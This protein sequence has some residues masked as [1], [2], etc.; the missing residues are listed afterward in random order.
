MD[1]R[2]TVLKLYVQE[3]GEQGDITDFESRKRFQKTVYLG[4][5]SGVDIG[6]RYG[7]YIKGPYST[8]L[9]QDYYAL[10]DAV[11]NGDDDHKKKSLNEAVRQ[12]L[13]RIK[14]LFSVPE[15]VDLDKANW[16]ELL[17]SWHF[18]IVVSKK[19]VADAINVMKAQ[20][21]AL[22]AY[23]DPADSVLRKFQLI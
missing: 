17:A 4:Q 13:A 16:L 1:D 9:T 6:Y 20:K 12:K 11:A 7:W 8:G 10:A 3:L 18:L 23:L 21:P 15:G 19:S 14:D 5:L 2:L 22:A